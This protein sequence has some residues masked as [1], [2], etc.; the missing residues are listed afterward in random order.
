MAL[1]TLF[2]FAAFVIG[3]GIRLLFQKAYDPGF[4]INKQVWQIIASIVVGAAVSLLLAWIGLR[5]WIG[6]AAFVVVGFLS[7]YWLE[8]LNKKK[9]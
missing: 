9:G 4:D 1:S 8:W 2:L 7:K 6:F 5:G 3:A